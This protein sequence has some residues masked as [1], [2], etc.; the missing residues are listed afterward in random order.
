MADSFS[1]V[2]C[3]LFP[4]SFGFWGCFVF[5][6]FFFSPHDYPELLQDG[7]TAEILFSLGWLPLQQMS[8]KRAWL[9]DNSS[10][11]GVGAS[12]SLH[13]SHAETLQGAIGAALR[14]MTA[15]SREE[16]KVKRNR[17]P[18]SVPEVCI[19]SGPCWNI[20]SAFAQETLISL[21]LFLPSLLGL[22]GCT[23]RRVHR[24]MHTGT[25]GNPSSRFRHG[26]GCCRSS[27][28]LGA[29][30]DQ[31]TTDPPPSCRDTLRLEG[32]QGAIFSFE[33][34]LGYNFP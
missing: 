22:W 34:L 21:D 3:S 11:K 19:F 32:R 18:L 9:W 29:M 16:N 4:C 13:P 20:C 26:G 24:A 2:S 5:L 31:G 17:I 14:L 33:S 23:A 7:E 30:Q 6:F 12:W 1:S 28:C 27:M 8:N 25:W 15:L 10:P